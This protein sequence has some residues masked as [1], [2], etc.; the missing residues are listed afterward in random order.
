M[1]VSGVTNKQ[2][3]YAAV[4]GAGGVVPAGTAVIL[5][6]PVT[7]NATTYTLSLTASDATYTGENL[8]HGSDVATETTGGEVFY[9]LTYGS[10]A[11][12]ENVF[13]WYWGAA[14]GAAFSI[15]AHKAWLAVTREQAGLDGGTGVKSFALPWNDCVGIEDID[16]REQ[17]A[18]LFEA[19][20]DLQGRRVARPT[21]GLYIVNGKKVAIK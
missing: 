7:T 19:V 9:K 8:L 10:E 6:G 13:G 17:K 3:T 18:S 1:V 5:C 2:L 11:G 15:G 21:S 4:A 20:Y 16:G 14:N 12:H